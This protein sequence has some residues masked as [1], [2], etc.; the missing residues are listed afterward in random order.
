MN[1]FL[2]NIKTFLTSKTGIKTVIV[3]V[4]LGIAIINPTFAADTTNDSWSLLNTVTNVLDDLIKI[5]AR[6]WIPLAIIAGKLMTNEFVYGSFMHMDK[7]LW[8]IWNIMKNFA[9]FALAAMILIE[10]I[11]YL[12]D[13]KSPQKVII[14]ALIAGVGI[15]ASWFIVGWLVDIST[16]LTSTIASFP[17]AFIWENNLKTSIQKWVD[18]NMRSFKMVIEKDLTISKVEANPSQWTDTDKIRENIMPKYNSVSGP[19]IYMGMS[20]LRLQ[21]FM[22]FVAEW[23]KTIKK[24]SINFALK[25]MITLFFTITLLLLCIAN[26]I[27]IV[28]L[29]LVVIASPL[30][31]LALAF[32][33]KPEGGWEWAMKYLKIGVIINTIFKPVIFVGALSLMLIFIVSIQDVMWTKHHME[34]NWVSLSKTQNTSTIGIENVWSLSVNDNFFTSAQAA[35]EDASSIFTDLIIYFTTLF[36]MRFLIKKAATTGG[37]P[38]ESAMEWAT[39][40]IEDFAKTT[41]IVPWWFSAN[42]IGGGINKIKGWIEDKVWFNLTSWENTK[43]EREA[44]NRIN[45]MFWLNKSRSSY[46]YRQLERELVK[47]G[48]YFGKLK[49]IA[50]NQEIAISLENNTIKTWIEAFLSNQTK[51]WIK[52]QWFEI[53]KDKE[54]T[55]EE[56]FKNSKNSKNNIKKLHELLWWDENATT[57]DPDSYE[58][59]LK[60]T[61]F[62]KE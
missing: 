60:N 32:W 54:K 6:A 18:T 24:V 21:D 51:E 62:K 33:K 20:S 46:E 5:V 27:R 9:N 39:K 42:S 8:T 41:P 56:I 4:M 55:F 14:S 12:K 59:L 57:K 53:D 7:Y 36:L 15:Q 10:I 34:V 61:Y 1:K 47:W 11:K 22:N 52:W 26:V 49:E 29:W 38:I 35:T 43:A 13:G 40:T 45:K 3:L 23:D 37:G 25:F 19:L 28:F 50:K 30:L 2:A 17:S 58:K 48:D 31:I 44:E 16:V